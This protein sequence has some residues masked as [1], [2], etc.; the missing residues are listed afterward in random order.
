M[1]RALSQ[2][3]IVIVQAAGSAILTV[4]VAGGTAG[5]NRL[6]DAGI[7]VG[8]ALV[9]S[10]IFFSPEPVRMLRRAESNAL[11]ELAS[12]LGRIA[13]AL[14]AN[15]MDAGRQAL[16]G[17]RDV[18]DRLVEVYVNGV[19]VCDPI[20]LDRDITPAWLQLVTVQSRDAVKAKQPVRAEFERITVWPAEVIPLPDARGAARHPANP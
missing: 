14:H 6:L 15:D 3:R 18:R 20:A 5:L 16:F 7:G 9:F 1:A 12:G 13:A 8:V 10:Q 2:E 17:L 4:A 19:A 11:A